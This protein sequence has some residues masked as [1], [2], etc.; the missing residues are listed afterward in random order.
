MFIVPVG[1]L[2]SWMV[3]YG[4]E[5]MR[6]SHWIVRALELLSDIDLEDESDLARFVTD[7]H[8]YLLS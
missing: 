4:L 5:R 8:D 2:E 6:K 1:E 3:P 7:M